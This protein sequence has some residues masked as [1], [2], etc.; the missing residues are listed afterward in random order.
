MTNGEKFKEVF[1]V[2][3]VDEGE[4]YAYAWLANHDAAE[5]SIDWWNEE[6]KEP[7]TKN[8]LGVDCISR[9]ATINAIKR[10]HPVDTDYDCTLYDKVDVMYVLDEM[11]SVIPQ[12]PKSFKWCE[13]CKEYDTEKHCCHRY[14]KVIRDTVAEIRQGLKK[15]ITRRRQQGNE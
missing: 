13:T 7:T 5:F 10:I 1:G 11:P 15:H 8:D 3:Q 4:L 14:S 2:S 9:Q 12:E 6:Y